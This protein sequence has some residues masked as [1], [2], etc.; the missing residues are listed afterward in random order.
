MRGEQM[1][2]RLLMA[3]LSFSTVLS[4]VPVVSA[5][6]QEGAVYVASNEATGNRILQFLRDEHGVLTAAASFSTGGLGTGT[7]LGNQGGVVLT[8]SGEWL[9]V[10]NAGSDDISVFAVDSDSNSLTLFDR[11]ASAG[12]RP[13]S[14]A[15]R[16]GLVYVLNT[17]G[18]LG[19]ADNI[20]GFR[21]N[22]RGRLVPI[23]GSTAPLSASN[24]G[25][26]EIHF[27]SDDDLLFVTEKNTNRIDVFQLDEAGAIRSSRIFSST[28]VEPFG[29]A[30]SRVA[31]AILVSNA[32]GGAANASS[33]TSYRFEDGMLSV[34]AGP[35]PT[36]QT[37]ACWVVTTRSGRFAYTTN[38]GSASLS[39][40]AIAVDGS[41]TLLNSDGITA[42]TGKGPIDAGF[43]IDDRFLFVLGSGDHSISAFSV[44]RDGSLSG[45]GT[46]TG[47]S[48]ASNGLAAR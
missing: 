40:Y 47:L 24:T 33:V 45:V 7:G 4:F 43:S 6:S 22:Q 34:L 19:E 10:V 1:R 18:A 28:G 48:P 16:H 13:I 39:G 15:T 8:E 42:V 38:T 30:V 11:K 5:E 37:A 31:D 46:T 26:A 2:F 3:A 29:F 25:P 20:S 44:Q 14:I 17:G 36:N 41:A 9:L 35:A 27:G 23:P 21:L 12:R 32:A